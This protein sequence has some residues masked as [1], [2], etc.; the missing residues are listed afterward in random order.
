MKKECLKNGHYLREEHGFSLLEM[1]AVLAVM[2]IM[3]GTIAPNLIDGIDRATSSAEK[4]NLDVM[5]SNL[6]KYIDR[7]KTIPTDQSS[8]WSAAIAAY[9]DVPPAQILENSKHYKRALYID[10]HFFTS[11]NKR[12]PG[13]VQNTGLTKQP[14]SPRMMLV[15]MLKSN[16]PRAPTTAA[17]FDAIWEQSNRASVVESDNVLI[18]RINLSSMFHRFIVT[19]QSNSQ[20]GYRIENGQQ[21]AVPASNNGSDGVLTRYILSDSQIQLYGATYPA[22]KLLTTMLINTSASYQFISNTSSNGGSVNGVSSGTGSS[23]K[24]VKKK[25]SKKSKG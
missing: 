2:A 11:S 16:V 22:G 17:K 14:V 12:F 1:I 4:V 24:N 8:S 5:S 13:Y 23:S 3:A 9:S 25:K 20:T 18:K 21:L 15:S 19:N 10:P 7:S 6:I